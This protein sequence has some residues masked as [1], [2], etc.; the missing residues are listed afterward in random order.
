[1]FSFLTD[2][3]DC[4]PN[5]CKNQGTCIDKVNSYSCSCVAKFTGENC[6]ELVAPSKKKIYHIENDEDDQ[7]DDDDDDD[8]DSHAI[9]LKK[10]GYIRN[11]LFQ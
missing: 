11:V 6:H 8:D 2:I 7:D 9:L 10:N 5:P 4:S 1:M 3:D